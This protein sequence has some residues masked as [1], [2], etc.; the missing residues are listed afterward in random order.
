MAITLLVTFLYGGLIWGI[1]PDFYPEKNISWESHLM[2]LV[3]GFVL[4]IYYRNT[5]PQRKKYSWDFEKELDDDE[6]ENAFWN[7]KDTSEL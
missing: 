3:A 5:G 1:L 6:D 7:T 2:G 4:A